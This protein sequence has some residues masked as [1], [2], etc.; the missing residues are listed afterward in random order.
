MLAAHEAMVRLSSL[1]NHHRRM[2]IIMERTNTLVV[3]ARLLKINIGAY[4]INNIK[5]TLDIANEL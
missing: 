1:I 5:F 2:T 3:N 4:Y